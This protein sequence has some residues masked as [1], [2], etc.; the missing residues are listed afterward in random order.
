MCW[1]TLVYWT[2]VSRGQCVCS[3]CLYMYMHINALNIYFEISLLYI[4][5]SESRKW[6]VCL[7]GLFYPSSLSHCL[8]SGFWVF[9]C[10]KC[11]FIDEL[12]PLAPGVDCMS[13]KTLWCVTEHVEPHTCSPLNKAGK[14]MELR[15]KYSSFGVTGRF[16]PRL[17]LPMVILKKEEGEVEKLTL[18]TT[19]K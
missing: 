15:T 11:Q 8:Q 5:K 17:Q 4:K 13:D 9:I 18:R 19:A 16:L 2:L 7:C 1:R 14:A 12:N 3:V 10:S 6:E